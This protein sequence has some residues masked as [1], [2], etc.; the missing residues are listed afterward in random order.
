ML[1]IPGTVSKQFTNFI[2]FNL[3][4]A[5]ISVNATPRAVKADFKTLKLD[6]S[7]FNL[8]LKVKETSIL[9]KIS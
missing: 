5:S 6:L 2:P 8:A 9:D 3:I 7:A 1:I 4:G